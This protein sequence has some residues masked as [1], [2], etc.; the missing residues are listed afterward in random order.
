M[1]RVMP[2]SAAVLARHE[3]LIH[4][5]SWRRGRAGSAL[6][7][8]EDL[9]QSLRLTV[10]EVW[11]RHRR[12]PSGE[13]DRIVRT[14]L[15]R[16]ISNLFAAE[17]RWTD[18]EAVAV[19]LGWLGEAVGRDDAFMALFWAELQDELYGSLSDLSF[20][21]FRE[22]THPT[23]GFQW[24]LE[25]GKRTGRQHREAAWYFGVP[26]LVL[27]CALREIRRSVEETLGL[28]PGVFS[29]AYL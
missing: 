29:S 17:R 27:T 12:K 20:A 24:A 25:V 4:W 26:D 10:A 21:V 6:L 9:A 18:A 19:H 3:R 28:M 14:A 13:L 11:R 7:N 22:L 15:T 5:L 8:P 2:K 16:S 23:P 1:G